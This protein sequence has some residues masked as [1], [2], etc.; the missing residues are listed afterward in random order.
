[1]TLHIHGMILTHQ[2][3]FSNNHGEGEGITNTLQKIIRDGDQ[4]STVSAES[5][6]Y[7]LREGWQH[8]LKND[9]LNRIMPNH[10]RSEYRDKEFSQWSQHVDDDLLGFMHAKEETVSRRGVLEITRAISTTPWR[11]EVMSNF[12]TPGSNAGVTHSNPIPY[13]VEVHHTRYQYGFA[14]TPESIGKEGNN[15]TNHLSNEDRYKRVEL[16]LNGLTKLRRVG[17]T[18]A[19]Y[20]SDY[21][22][23]GII[24]RITDD[25]APRFLYCFDEDDRGA[26]KLGKLQKKIEGGDIE[27]SEVIIGTTIDIENLKELKAAG[28]VVESGVKAAVKKCL[29]TVNAKQEGKG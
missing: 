18:H 28:V 21:S 23:E 5:I 8:E 4:Y 29:E 27:A 17:G 26:I 2:C 16:S 13:A 25:P 7:A 15:G 12:A 1:M 24:L 19:R 10:R 14:I 20:F 11:G 9:Q 6:R 22:P 3:T